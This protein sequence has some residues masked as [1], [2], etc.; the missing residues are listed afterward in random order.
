[1]RRFS[2]RFRESGSLIE[3]PEPS[4]TSYKSVILIGALAP[5]VPEERVNGFRA[6]SSQEYGRFMDD[7][8]SAKDPEENTGC[9]RRVDAAAGWR[10]TECSCSVFHSLHVG[11]RPKCLTNSLPQLVQMCIRAWLAPDVPIAFRVDGLDL[12]LNSPYDVTDVG[13]RKSCTFTDGG[14]SSSSSS[15]SSSNNARFKGMVEGRFFGSQPCV[16]AKLFR[17]RT[18]VGS[19]VHALDVRTNQWLKTFRKIDRS[20]EHC[21]DIMS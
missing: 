18:R 3:S 20:A 7:V 5:A 1:M 8:E 16:T 11:Q 21:L 19:M 6:P 2:R 17:R 10:W 13:A 14:S 12:P 15:S 9:G 4:S